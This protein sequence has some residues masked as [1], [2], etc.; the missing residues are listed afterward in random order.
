MTSI[1]NSSTKNCRQNELSH[2]MYRV[3]KTNAGLVRQLHGLG[4][5]LKASKEQ[6]NNLTA[7]L[8]ASEKKNQELAD[9]LEASENE[10][11]KL[12]TV[13]GEEQEFIASLTNVTDLARIAVKSLKDECSDAYRD[14][15]RTIMEFDEYIGERENNYHAKLMVSYMQ[16]EERDARIAECDACIAERDDRIAELEALVTSLLLK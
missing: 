4:E 1:E 2:T 6:T 15:T 11:R 7:E 3:Q 16:I 9:K 5:T 14:N 8:E 12:K 10:N 13:L